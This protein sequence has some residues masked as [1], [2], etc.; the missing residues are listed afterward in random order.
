L[1]LIHVE[2]RPDLPVPFPN[3]P[4]GSFDGIARIHLAGRDPVVQFTCG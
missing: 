2:K 4:E 3:P 1:I